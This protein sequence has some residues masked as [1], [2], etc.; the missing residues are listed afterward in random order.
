MERRD[1]K[2]TVFKRRKSYDS[3]DKELAADN[4]TMEMF[5]KEIDEQSIMALIMGN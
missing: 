1:I 2:S 3:L 5:L 4:K